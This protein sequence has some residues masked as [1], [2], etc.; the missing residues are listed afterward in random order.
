MKRFTVLLVLL[1]SLS[2]ISL[3][4]KDI[5]A[6]KSE[7]TMNQQFDV[8]KKNLKYWNGSYFLNELQLNQ[9]YNAL[10]DS[11]IVFEK[12]VTESKNQL[13]ALQNELNA[14]IKE[15]EEIQKKLDRSIQLENSISILGVDINKRVYSLSMYILIIGVLIISGLLILLYIRSNKITQRT[16]NDFEELKE[17]F[18]LH[19]KNALDRYVKMNIEL[20][21]A[22][23][24]LNKK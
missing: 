14:K 7:K 17:E 3:A 8:F 15:T 4:N 23:F 6:W 20:T 18:E 12:E 16:K 11:A 21:K 5:D 22:R 2:L 19:K 1:V 13:I 24:E 9:F 10:R